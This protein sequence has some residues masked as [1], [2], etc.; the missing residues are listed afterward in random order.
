MRPEEADT[1]ATWILE[2]DLRPGDV[3]LNIGSSTKYFREVQQPHLQDR[4]I[5]PLEEVGIRFVHC[6]MKDAEGVDEVGDILDPQFR[7]RLKRHQA[8]LLVCSNLLEHLE[9]PRSFASA[10]PELVGPGGYGIFS[11]PYR[12]PYHPD[13]IDTM[14]RPA[15]EELAT[16]LPGWTTMRTGRVTIGNYW[17][18]LRKK[19]KPL[20][21]LIR[22]AARVAMPFYRPH[23]W[24]ANASRLSWLFRT[25]SVS[26]VLMK[27][28]EGART[29]PSP[30]HAMGNAIVS[31]SSSQWRSTTHRLL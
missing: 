16:L 28:A 20:L 14:L 19:G 3:C 1:L 24:R 23:T 26:I 8:K 29:C 30:R 18:D 12:Y 21:R 2:L 31:H 27:K 4:F 17:R 10:C 7:S 15:P 22:H 9:D 13:P 11:V 6:D 5:R 25:Y